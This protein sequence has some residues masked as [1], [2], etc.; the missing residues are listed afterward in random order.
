M[1]PNFAR[2]WSVSN[3]EIGLS[4]F[5]VFVGML[6]YFLR[7]Y[8][9]SRQHLIDLGLATAYLVFSFA[10]DYFCVRNF[11][12]FVAML[13]GDAVVMTFTLIV[14]RQL[15]FQRL[16]G[17]FVPIIF[18]TC[19]F[20]H[21]MEGLSYW[22][23]TYPLNVPWMM[24]T[25]DCGFAVLVNTARFPGLIRGEDVMEQLNIEKAR[26]EV[27]ENEI[28]ARALAEAHL[29]DSERRREAEALRRESFARNVMLAMTGGRL[30]LHAD[31]SELP[32]PLAD[33]AFVRTP[34]SRATLGAARRQIDRLAQTLEFPPG[35]RHD[36]V[37]AA[38]EAMMNAVVHATEATC[39]VSSS[40]AAIQVRVDDAGGG[41]DWEML[42][43]ATLQSGWSSKGTLGM[44]FT[45]MAT[46][47]TV[48][49]LT[50]PQ[51]TTIV[52]T[53]ARDE[54]FD[55]HFALAFGGQGPDE[56]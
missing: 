34:L 10:L 45:V 16:L 14:S 18:L 39:T 24:V 46:A 41:L 40:G 48:E 36:L 55:S 19:A 28:A 56:A 29:H 21:F 30:H 17:I 52:L 20:G 26:V 50:G 23:L 33:I 7:L 44:G 27:L 32:A 35:R 51:G 9:E 11:E 6:Y 38:A 22:K 13:I 54:G 31:S 15:W 5:G 53:M 8:H 47:D 2:I 37:S 4:Y 25:A 3:I 12:P 1:N 43:Y 49:I 42:P